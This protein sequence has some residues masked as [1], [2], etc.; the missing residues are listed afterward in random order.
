MANYAVLSQADNA[1]IDDKDPKI[2]YDALKGKSEDY[3][4][5]QLFFIFSEKRDSR[6]MSNI[7]IFPLLPFRLRNHYRIGAAVRTPS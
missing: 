4:D 5:E 2:V 1:E 7:I 6:D 3:A